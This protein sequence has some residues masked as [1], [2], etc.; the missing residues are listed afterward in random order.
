MCRGL[1]KALTQ[2]YESVVD[3]FQLKIIAKRRDYQTFDHVMEHLADLLF[4]RDPVLRQRAH[5]RLTRVVLFYMY[6]N[7]DIGEAGGDN[8]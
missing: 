8:A 7:C 4:N 3:E 1:Q 2:L 6:W 5:K